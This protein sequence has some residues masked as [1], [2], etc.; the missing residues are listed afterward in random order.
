MLADRTLGAIVCALMLCT[1]GATL[2]AEEE[3]PD[4]ELLEYLGMWEESDEDW[5][6]LDTAMAAESKEGSDPAP[7][8]EESME[9][10]DES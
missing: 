5:V 2:A 9:N 3:L 10:D 1:P 7:Q 4:M 8:G 6:I